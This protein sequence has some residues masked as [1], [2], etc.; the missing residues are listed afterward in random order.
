VRACV[1]A[2]ARARVCVCVCLFAC[3]SVCVCLCTCACAGAGAGAGVYAC[4][5]VCGCIRACA[6]LATVYYPLH[7]SLLQFWSAV[8]EYDAVLSFRPPAP[9]SAVALLVIRIDVICINIYR[10]IY[11]YIY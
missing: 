4:L 2:R 8:R 9:H 10:H 3:V 7:P 6:R 11:I 1:C 5:R